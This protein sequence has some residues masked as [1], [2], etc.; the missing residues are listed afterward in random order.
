MGRPIPAP[1]WLGDAGIWEYQPGSSWKVGWAM[2]FS[3]PGWIFQ[4]PGEQIHPR[5]PQDRGHPTGR[6]GKSPGV[7]PL[8]LDQ[9]GYFGTGFW[10]ILRTPGTFSLPRR[11]GRPGRPGSPSTPSVPRSPLGPGGPGTQQEGG[12]H[13]PD[14]G[15]C[16]GSGRSRDLQETQEQSGGEGA[17]GEVFR[18]FEFPGFTDIKFQAGLHRPAP[19]A[20]KIHL[21]A[22]P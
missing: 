9:P 10:G 5:V 12:N 1:A 22:P 11:P 2:T 6:A 20:R 18:D 19:S 14:S 8:A 15:M 3:P 16:S 13:I 21:E 17:A 7:F 4:D